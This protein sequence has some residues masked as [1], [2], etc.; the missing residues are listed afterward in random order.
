MSGDPT[1]AEMA[2]AMGGVVVDLLGCD[3]GRKVKVAGDDVQCWEKATRR[4][5]IHDGHGNEIGLKFCP[6]HFGR[7]EAETVPHRERAA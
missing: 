4:M 3:Y 7:V 1:L 6:E 5:V 2:S